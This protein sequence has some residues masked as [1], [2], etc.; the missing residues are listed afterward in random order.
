MRTTK[1]IENRISEMK[2]KFQ[3]VIPESAEWI[4]QV[5]FIILPEIN[6]LRFIHSV[7]LR[8]KA[9]T[10]EYLPDTIAEAIAGENG[11]AVLI[12]PENI[13]DSSECLF[14]IA[15]E[16]GHIFSNISNKEV[17]EECL[18][19]TINRIDSPMRS[20]GA[21]WSEF[22]AD[23]IATHVTKQQHSR[24]GLWGLADHAFNLLSH[25]TPEEELIPSVLGHFCA[26]LLCNKR[27][28][29]AYLSGEIDIG[30]DHMRP[31]V[32]SII[33]E[34]LKILDAQLQDKEFWLISREQMLLLGKEIDLLWDE[35]SYRGVYL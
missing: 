34:L 27:L 8:L 3:A 35:C 32:I 20:G 22:I 28:R 13:Y 6:R 2:A 24:V 21:I 10:R 29:K 16:L 4:E 31:A 17:N 33:A 14:T 11:Y 1:F 19:D 5:E 30:S 23:A 12:Y 26:F 7:D 9:R 18:K 25:F 15:H